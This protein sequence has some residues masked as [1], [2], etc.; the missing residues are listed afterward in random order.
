VP[1]INIHGIRHTFAT[2]GVAGGAAS[3]SIQNLVRHRDV[4][5]TLEFYVHPTRAMEQAAVNIISQQFG[6]AHRPDGSL[7][8]VAPQP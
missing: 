1:R 8:Q 4:Q 5:T 7:V 3:N 6:P 2:T